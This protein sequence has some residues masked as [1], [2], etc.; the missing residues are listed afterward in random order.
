MTVDVIGHGVPTDATQ[1]RKLLDRASFRTPAACESV[2]WRERL[3]FTGYVPRP[4]MVHEIITFAE[5]YYQDV[6]SG[7]TVGGVQQVALH[8]KVMEVSRT[9]LR[10]LGLDWKFIGDNVVITQGAAGL[11]AQA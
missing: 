7:I 5:D 3:H 4:E 8:V 1:L 6:I 2:R 9:K 11:F 10:Q